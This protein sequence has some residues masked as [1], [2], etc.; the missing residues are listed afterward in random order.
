MLLNEVGNHTIFTPIVSLWSYGPLNGSFPE[1]S[2]RPSK[3]GRQVPHVA[4]AS[5]EAHVEHDGGVV[6][7][8]HAIEHSVRGH[9]RRVAEPH[10]PP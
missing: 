7:L 9:G 10:H 5:T 4:A 1:R 8:G 2:L 3:G 6:V